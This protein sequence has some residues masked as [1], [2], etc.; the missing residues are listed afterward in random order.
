MKTSNSQQPSTHLSARIPSITLACAL[1]VFYLGM[2][3]SSQAADQFVLVT[4][5]GWTNSSQYSW[6]GAWGDYDKDGFVDLF[7]PN[8]NPSTA[9]GA[10]TN[11]LYHNNG[12]G[13]FS[14]KFA[15]QAGFIASDTNPSI[16][17]VRGDVNNDGWLDL[18]PFNS[19][20]TGSSPPLISP[21]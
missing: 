10:W 15:E 18:I 11:F 6:S 1:A 12:D 2:A 14:R 20:K 17:A 21:L 3:S 4:N 13:T 8:T 19:I 7:V 5:P 9:S 16:G